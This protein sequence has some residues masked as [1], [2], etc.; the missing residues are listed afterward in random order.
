MSGGYGLSNSE[1]PG[2]ESCF[3]QIAQMTQIGE[4]VEF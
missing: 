3:S 4:V 2:E 1:E